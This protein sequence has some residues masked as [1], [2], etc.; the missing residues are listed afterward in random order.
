MRWLS[1]H[2][3]QKIADDFAGAEPRR[4]LLDHAVLRFARHRRAGQEIPQFRRFVVRGAKIRQLLASTGSA[5][6]CSS[7]MSAKAVAYCRLADFNS[8]SPAGFAR[9]C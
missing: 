8:A 3:K 1:D 6:P 5:A 9:N 2:H 7:A 4:Q